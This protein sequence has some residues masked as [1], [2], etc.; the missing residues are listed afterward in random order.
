MQHVGGC[1]GMG[2]FHRGAV[3]RVP[4][5]EDGGWG[6]GYGWAGFGFPQGNAGF[7]QEGLPQEL[8]HKIVDFQKTPW[9]GR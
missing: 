2:R 1:F 9:L 6:S 5:I 4:K 7:F 3:D 8:G